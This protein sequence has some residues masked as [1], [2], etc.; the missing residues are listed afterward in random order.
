MEHVGKPFSGGRPY[1]LSQE[2][3]KR[4]SGRFLIPNQFPKLAIE[5]AGL[6]ITVQ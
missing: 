2:A 6:V 1:L 3:D 5:I 4:N